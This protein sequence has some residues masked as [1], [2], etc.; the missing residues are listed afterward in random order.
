MATPRK[1]ALTA[2]SPY[3][4]NYGNAAPT[5][6][7]SAF[8][9]TYAPQGFQTSAFNK[10]LSQGSNFDPN[11]QVLPMQQ[12]NGG[13]GYGDSS[14]PTIATSNSALYQTPKT[15]GSWMDSLK[16]FFTG[17]KDVKSSAENL[18]GGISALAG[19]YGSYKTG[20]YQDKMAKLQ[21]HASDVYDQ[22]LAAKNQRLAQAQANYEA[23]FK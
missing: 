18:A 22:E 23:S 15:D 11:E 3:P 20:Q 9:S 1:S 13:F 12:D 4:S 7:A 2:Y 14:V 8:G 10:Y 19:L 17:S 16:G 21:Q 6:N 5:S